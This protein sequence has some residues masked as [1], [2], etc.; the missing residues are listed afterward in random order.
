MAIEISQN[1][2]IFGG[3][4]NGAKKKLALLFFG[5]ERIEGD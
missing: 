1:K 5:E 2:E 4:K 3:G